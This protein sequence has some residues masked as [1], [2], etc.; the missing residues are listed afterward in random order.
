MGL[1]WSQCPLDV[2][3]RELFHADTTEPLRA[4]LVAEAGGGEARAELVQRRRRPA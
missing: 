4:Q 3:S 2:P 1:L